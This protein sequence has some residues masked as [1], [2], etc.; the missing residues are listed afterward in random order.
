MH[1]RPFVRAGRFNRDASRIDPSA[2]E[3]SEPNAYRGVIDGELGERR[4]DRRIGENPGHGRHAAILCSDVV[5]NGPFN[6]AMT[7]D[8]A[9]N[10][11]AHGMAWCRV[12]V[13]A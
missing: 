4:R 8:F 7:V 13:E 11:S 9:R 3:P 2:A 12:T 1:E 10:S 6:E 5:V